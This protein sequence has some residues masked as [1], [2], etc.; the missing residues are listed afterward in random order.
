MFR[1]G[2]AKLAAASGAPALLLG[3]LAVAQEPEAMA[4]PEDVVITEQQEEQKL[5]D[6][7]IGLPVLALSE[8]ATAEERVGTVDTLLFDGEDAIAGIVVGIG[9]FLGLGAKSVAI[10]YGNVEVREV[11]GVPVAAYV[12]LTREQLEGA[13]DFK[14]KAALEAER[15]QQEMEMELEQQQPGDP[16][17]PPQP[18]E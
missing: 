16:Q 9:G 12:E 17:Q 2:F 5:A 11:D 7:L 10:A 4:A 18:I 1:N 8:D 3:G 14:T 15:Q 13:P 6:D